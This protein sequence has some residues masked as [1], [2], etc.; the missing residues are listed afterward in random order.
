MFLAEL[1]LPSFEKIL[2]D[3][4]VTAVTS[5]HIKKK[6]Y[7]NWCIFC[8]DILILKMEKINTHFQHIMLYYFKKGKTATETHTKKRFVQHMEKML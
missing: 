2:L 8:A 1:S 6:T 7:Q 3:C 5:A 4:T